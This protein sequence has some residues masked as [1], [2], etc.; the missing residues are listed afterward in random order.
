MYGN[1]R[2]GSQEV[3]VLLLALPLI[4]LVALSKLLMTL[5]SFSFFIIWNHW[6]LKLSSYPKIQQFYHLLTRFWDSLFIYSAILNLKASKSMDLGKWGWGDVQV[7]CLA[8]AHLSSWM[9]CLCFFNSNLRG[10]GLLKHGKRD[11]SHPIFLSLTT[12]LILITPF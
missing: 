6:T 4:H 8:S 11:N 5:L 12:H 9:S 2:V 1:G 7:S 10:Q 3:W